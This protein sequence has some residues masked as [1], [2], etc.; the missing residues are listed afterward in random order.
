MFSE[1][2][3]ELLTQLLSQIR[4]DPFAAGAEEQFRKVRKAG[5]EWRDY[6]QAEQKEE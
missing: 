3:K 4:I 2:T 1:E 5:E 6:L